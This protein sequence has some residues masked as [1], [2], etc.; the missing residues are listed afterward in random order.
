MIANLLQCIDGFLIWKISAIANWACKNSCWTWKWNSGASN[1]CQIKTKNKLF[2]FIVKQW[3]YNSSLIGDKILIVTNNTEAYKIKSNNCIFNPE[4]ESNHKEAD[5]RMMLRVKHASI[6]YS[7]IVIY[8]PDTDVFMIALSKI[9]ELDCQLYLKT[10]TKSHKRTIGIITVA[11]CVNRNIKKTD[12][13]KNAFLKAL[14]AFHFFA[15]CD[16]T[17]S[18]TG[19]SRLKSLY[20]LSS[21]EN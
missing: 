18:F 1:Y 9:L 14:L 17:S 5:S 13:N 3:I 2:N 12:C 21:N 15:G 6:T 4:L 11:Q 10:S 20:L 16:S 8:T 19:K 7:T